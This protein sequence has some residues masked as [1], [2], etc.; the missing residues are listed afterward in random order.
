VP[1]LEIVA[2]GGLREAIDAALASGPER[3]GRVAVG[4]ARC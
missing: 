3:S 1:G 2:V 4:S